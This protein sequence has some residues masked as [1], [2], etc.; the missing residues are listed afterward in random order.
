MVVGCE[1]QGRGCDSMGVNEKCSAC[2][3][4]TGVDVHCACKPHWTKEAIEN[5]ILCVACW[6]GCTGR[7]VVAEGE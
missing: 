3:D 5:P 7:A 1:K 4:N 6:E 2:F